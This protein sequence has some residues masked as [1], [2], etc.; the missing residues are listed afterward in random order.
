MRT[1]IATSSQERIGWTKSLFY[2]FCNS[3]DQFCFCRASLDQLT[4]ACVRFLS[5]ISNA[6]SHWLKHWSTIYRKH[7]LVT[8]YS[9]KVHIH[10]MCRQW[11]VVS[12]AH[13]VRLMKQK[14]CSMTTPSNGSISRV[15]DHLCGEFTGHWWIAPQRPV[16]WS[17][18]V[19]LDLR[20]NKR[21]SRHSWGWLYETPS[22]PFWRHCNA[23][24]G[25]F[26]YV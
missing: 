26:C 7:A 13:T 6:F 9:V 24:I 2:F 22:H 5:M 14:F 15:T 3:C 18:D 19:F 20:L 21:L 16:T 17:S 8:A 25:V 23:H 12:S 1:N 10:H 11:L 4:V